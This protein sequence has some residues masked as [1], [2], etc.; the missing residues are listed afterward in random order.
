MMDLIAWGLIGVIFIF[1]SLTLKA[2]YTSLKAFSGESMIGRL[3]R[4][5]LEVF[6]LVTISYF[7]IF[8]FLGNFLNLSVSHIMV[9]FLALASW[10]YYLLWKGIRNFDKST[11]ILS[12]EK[13]I[14]GF[15]GK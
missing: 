10:S 2:F 14:R 9:V 15:F 8:T 4:K 6:F 12:M 7:F 1:F 3:L 13:R 5:I 11:E